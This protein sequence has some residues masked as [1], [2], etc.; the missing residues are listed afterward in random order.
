MAKISLA[1]NYCRLW[2]A[3]PS[4]TP[5][6]PP[7]RLCYR[8]LRAPSSPRMA[9]GSSRKPEGQQ[10]AYYSF[11]KPCWIVCRKR[12]ANFNGEKAEANFKATVTIAAASSNNQRSA[13]NHGKKSIEQQES[14]LFMRFMLSANRRF[15]SAECAFSFL[16]TSRESSTDSRRIT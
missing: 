13:F 14:A 7:T 16:S 9:K 2:W 4:R 11:I 15:H 3:T 12:F 8:Q 10:S 5:A 1:I 6:Q